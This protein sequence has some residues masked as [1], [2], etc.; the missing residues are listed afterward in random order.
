[1]L[2]E[3]PPKVSEVRFAGTLFSGVTYEVPERSAAARSPTA[4]LMAV[5]DAEPIGVGTLS[6]LSLRAS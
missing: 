1:M 3:R 2:P 4:A 5:R 6:A